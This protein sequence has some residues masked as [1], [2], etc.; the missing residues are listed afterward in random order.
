MDEVLMRV[1]GTISPENQDPC[2]IV[3][4]YIA[5]L[6]EWINTHYYDKKIIMIVPSVKATDDFT[7]KLKENL[8]NIMVVSEGSESLLAALNVKDGLAIDCLDGLQ[9]PISWQDV[10]C[11]LA[12]I[13][14]GGVD[15]D[16]NIPDAKYII[17][18]EGISRDLIT[19]PRVTDY[20]KHI[21]LSEVNDSNMHFLAPMR[22]IAPIV[23]PRTIHKYQ[24]GS[25]L[26]FGGSSPFQSALKLCARAASASGCGWVMA[27]SESAF[28]ESAD[29]GII[30][31]SFDDPGSRFFF[32][33]ASVC[34][35]GVGMGHG[36]LAQHYIEHLDAL[37]IIDAGAFNYIS[38]FQGKKLLTPHEGEL[39][40]ILGV[41][42]DEVRQD[43]ISAAR[44]ASTQFN[45]SV[46]LKG[47]GPILVDSG[48]I[49]VF[50]L[51][52]ASLAVAGSG[53]IMAGIIAG[54]CAQGLSIFDAVY[55]CI[56]IQSYLAGR[57]SSLH[58]R[59]YEAYFAD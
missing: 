22:S 32:S 53:D 55:R 36:S 2:F 48:N 37:N 28:D 26:I 15:V 29:E 13:G 14:A 6:A 56:S 57:Y 59:H 18:F 10:Q 42:V 52:S 50:A 51:S 11:D 1:L 58:W 34:V 24:R 4:K 17:S 27:V 33:R 9:V 44:K 7:R 39:A 45:A 30:W 31:T 54:F 3:I 35:W 40:D 20:H 46:L 41:S 21:L 5:S 12:V 23:R 38:K 43:R 8:P 19:G 47:P 49:Y 25:C 16:G